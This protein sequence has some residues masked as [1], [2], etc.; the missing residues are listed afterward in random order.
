[1]AL[2][3]LVPLKF[4]GLGVERPA[5]LVDG[6]LVDVEQDEARALGVGQV[7]V[8]LLIFV[9]AA[10]IVI[11]TTGVLQHHPCHPVKHLVRS[12]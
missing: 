7:L 5:P 9:I 3:L 2:P 1:M 10:I 4:D 8:L 12:S 11:G 6:V